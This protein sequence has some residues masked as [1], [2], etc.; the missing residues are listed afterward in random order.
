VTRT[1]HLRELIGRDR[2]LVLPSTYDPLLAK[3]IERAGFEAIYMAGSGVHASTLGVPDLGMMT[4]PE[5]L[6]RA[7]LLADVTSL[8]LLA[9]AEDGFGAPL[10]IMRTVRTYERAGIAAIQIEDLAKPKRPWDPKRVIPRDRMLGHL[11]AA[12]DARVDPDLVVIA[13]TDACAAVGLEEGIE[14]GLA[15]AAAGADVIQVVTP[16]PLEDLRAYPKAIAHPLMC[17]LQDAVLPADI[18]AH[19]IEAMGYRIAAHAT[20]LSRDL[21]SQRD[22]RDYAMVVVREAT[23]ARIGD[24]HEAS[25][26]SMASRY[27]VVCSLAEVEASTGASLP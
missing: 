14:R 1:R 21:V 27:A 17:N 4:F 8:P 16:R 22:S 24:L 10:D 20:A 11:K 25:L 13:R 7:R 26:R 3:C 9:D 23:G 12:L 19:E 18:S 15:Y 6:E 5:M 2:L